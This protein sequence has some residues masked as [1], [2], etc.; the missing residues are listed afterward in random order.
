MSNKKKRDAIAVRDSVRTA[1][2][3][4]NTTLALFDFPDNGE[5]PDSFFADFDGEDTLYASEILLHVGLNYAIKQ[6]IVTEQN[7][8]KKIA[9]YRRTLKEVFG[10]DVRKEI[11]AQKM[12]Y[13][14]EK[15]LN[16]NQDD[17]E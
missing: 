12:L 17:D 2:M 1:L 6:G 7:C 10:V 13:S 5:I 3:A 15:E 14:I 11:E 8:I 4:T 16:P 9:L